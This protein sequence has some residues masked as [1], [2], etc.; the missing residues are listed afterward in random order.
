MDQETMIL[1]EQYLDKDIPI[2]KKGRLDKDILVVGKECLGKGIL[3]PETGGIDKAREAKQ[4]FQHAK[5]AQ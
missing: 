2:L 3:N 1:E 5:V 4:I